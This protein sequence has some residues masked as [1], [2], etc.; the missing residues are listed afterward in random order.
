MC[1][2]DDVQV[3]IRDVTVK[4]SKLHNYGRFEGFN[5]NEGNSI[6]ELIGYNS[7]PDLIL[8]SYSVSGNTMTYEGYVVPKENV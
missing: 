7:I 4:N 8:E 3:T 1:S 5:P 2:E 6:G